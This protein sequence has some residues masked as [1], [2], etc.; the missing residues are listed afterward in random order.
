MTL[1]ET[2]ESINRRDSLPNR[3]DY[4]DLVEDTI[5]ILEHE[6]LDI[7]PT[8]ASGLSGGLIL[9]KKDIPTIILPDLHGR[10]NFFMD[11]LDASYKNEKT[12]LQALENDE[13]QLLCLGDGFHGEGRAKKRWLV[14][15]DEY[16][17][18]FEKH[19]AMDKEMIE[20]L[21]LMEMV[22]HCKT[23]LSDNFHFLKGNHEN[24]LNEEGNGN[25]KF[26]KYSFEGEMVYNYILKFYGE[27][28]LFTYSIFEKRLPLFAKGANFL[29]SHAEPARMY[30][31]KELINA[32]LLPEVILGLT[33]T[34]NDEAEPFSVRNMLDQYLDNPETGVYFGGHRPVADR[35]MLRANEKYVQIHN[36]Q[37]NNSVLIWPE[38]QFNTETDIID[39]NKGGYSGKTS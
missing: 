32:R 10:C 39:P 27:E 3:A 5:T 9:L 17:R 37:K 35:F 33:W 34:N 13:L 18:S 2:L 28:F 21:G 26:R 8:D 7:R 6:N 29:A 1:R 23:K 19:R 38:R 4:L 36:P 22:L 14:A 12:V 30:C 11:V 31:E 25:H 20:N 15:F 16:T 24:I